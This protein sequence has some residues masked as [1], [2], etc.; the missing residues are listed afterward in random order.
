VAQQHWNGRLSLTGVVFVIFLVG[1]FVVSGETPGA[2]DS[3]QEV[4]SFYSEN[5][6]EVMISAILS[7]LSAVFFLF[8]VGG[9][10][11]VLQFAEGPAAALSAVARAGGVV[12]A[13][14]MLIFAGL[15]FTLGDAADSLEPAATQTLNALNADFFFP[16]AA[17][18]ATFLLATGIVAVRTGALPPW[19]GWAALIIAV[20][21]F[22]PVGFFAFLA[23]IAWVLVA[24]ILLGLGK[25]GTTAQLA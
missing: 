13:V 25:V 1:S 18:M 3:T 19:L 12:A 4:V 7:A 21:S 22:T 23:S 2:D 24:S 14:G 5:D 15:M 8:F 11:S 20:A 10:A 6:A 9:L 16:L 17:G